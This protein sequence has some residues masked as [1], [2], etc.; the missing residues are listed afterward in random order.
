MKLINQNYQLSQS[1]LR[2][3][4]CQSVPKRVLYTVRWHYV[5]AKTTL[6]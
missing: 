3:L 5:A 6:K 4:S 2:Q 1:L